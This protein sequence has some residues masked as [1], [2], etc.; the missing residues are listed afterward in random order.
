MYVTGGLLEQKFTETDSA[1]PAP[2]NRP[3]LPLNLLCPRCK[4]TLSQAGSMHTLLSAQSMSSDLRLGLT[5]SLIGRSISSSYRETCGERWVFAASTAPLTFCPASAAE[6]QFWLPEVRIARVQGDPADCGDR[7]P[8][9]LGYPH[10]R[11][12]ASTA[13]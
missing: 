3:Y 6:G 7:C 8:L 9:G 1:T 12:F 4:W 10:P 5:E 13:R 2:P 11:Q